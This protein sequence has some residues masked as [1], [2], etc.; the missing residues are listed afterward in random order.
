MFC[1]DNN[2]F[3]L[4]CIKHTATVE[5]DL[6]CLKNRT[7]GLGATLGDL[8]YFLGTKFIADIKHKHDP[9]LLIFGLQTTQILQMTPYFKKTI[10]DF[11][12]GL[13]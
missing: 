6:L 1:Q 5:S 3:Y 9:T 2:T 10:A 8:L 4:R 7:G 13:I 11:Y 12:Q